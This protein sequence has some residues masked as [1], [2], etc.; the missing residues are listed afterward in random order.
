[1][2]LTLTFASTLL[3]CASALATPA[4]S[5]QTHVRRQASN[6]EI[7]NPISGLDQCDITTS[8]VTVTTG[9]GAN[10]TS[11]NPAPYSNTTAHYSNSTTSPYTNTTT[12]PSIP[13]SYCACRAG[14]KATHTATDGLIQWRLPWEG[15]EGRVFVRPGVVCDALCD[16][17]YLGAAGCSEV[18]LYSSCM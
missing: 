13:L 18:P 5:G 6:C 10:S 7:C 16:E 14:Y 17:W 8:C 4:L 3:I 1:M 2:K 9:Y 12:I 11:Y 15:Q